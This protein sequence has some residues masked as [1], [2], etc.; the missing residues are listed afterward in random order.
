[1]MQDYRYFPWSALF[2]GAALPVMGQGTW[3]R[4]YGGYS[5]DEG[6]AVIVTSDGDFVVAGNTGSFGAGGADIYVLKLDGNGEKIWS[7]TYGTPQMDHGTDVMETVDGG[8]V[9]AGFTNGLGNG[10]YD[11]YLVKLD[12]DGNL[13]WERTY[14]GADWEFLHAVCPAQGG[15]MVVAGL[16][17]G[18]GA[19]GGRAWLM[20]LDD[21]GEVVWERT[22]GDSMETTANAVVATSD[23]GY[24]M[25]G[26]ATVG[27]NQDA[28]LVKLNGDGDLGWDERVGGDSAEVATSVVELANGGFVAVGTTK[29]HG[30]HIEALEFKLDAVGELQWLQHWAQV[31]GEESMDV[32]ELGDGRLLS[33]GYAAGIGSG[34]KDMYILFVD[35]SGNFLSGITNGGDNG[36][37]DEVGNSVAVVP[38]GGYIIAGYTESFGFGT[39]DVYVVRTDS[40]GLTSSTSVESVFDPLAV[41]EVDAPVDRHLFPTIVRPGEEVHV[42]WSQAQIRTLQLVDARGITSWRLTL[43]VGEEK[44]TLPELAAGVYIVLLDLEDGTRRTGKIVV[45]D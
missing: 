23:G 7:R 6:K 41:P 18:D 14:G 5:L 10:G 20:K 15:G 28:W 29:S 33:V 13:L 3:Q 42:E 25:A 37:R 35:P 34:G 11:G 44:F 2:L 8:L 38:E 24:I 30:P 16:K 40:L 43:G 4:T 32:V 36:D 17:Y 19:G 31:S 26:A 1:M 12:G 9:V 21:M 22:Y 39:R 27:G 45:H